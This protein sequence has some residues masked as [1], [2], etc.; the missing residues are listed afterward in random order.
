M[1]RKTLAEN[2]Q[3]NKE[4]ILN[5]SEASAF[6][7]AG[8][9]KPKTVKATVELSV[10]NSKEDE[11]VPF[12][13]RIPKS[14]HLAMVDYCHEARKAQDGRPTTQQAVVM[15]ALEKWLEG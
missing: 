1:S 14:L 13:T 15:Q 9:E 12:A 3:T 6:I 11:L 2:L 7:D 8:R 10:D 5:S 4:S